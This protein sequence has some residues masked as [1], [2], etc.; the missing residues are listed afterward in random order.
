MK[1]N[2]YLNNDARPRLI[3]GIKKCAEAV[4]ATMGTSGSNAL[5]QAIEHPGH[6]ATNDGATILS[7]IKLADPI[8]DMGRL[9]LLEAVSRANKKSGDG[10]STAT[11]LTAAIIDAG[12]TVTDH[13]AMDIKRSLEACTELLEQ[14][15]QETAKAITVDDVAGVATISAE[16]ATIGQTIGDIYKQIGPDGIIHWDISKTNQDSYTIGN[17]ITIDGAGYVSPYM[18]DIDEKTGMFLNVARWK[19]PKVLITKQKI[20]TA[21]DFNSLFQNLYNNNIREVVIF[22]DEYEA[23]VIGDF[24][25]TRAVRGFKT[26]LVKMPVLWKDQWFIDLAK[27]SGATI[28]DPLAG[29][30]YKTMNESHLGTFEHIV[31]SKDSTFIDGIQNITEHI[32]ALEEE[33]TDDSK[34]RVARLNTKTARYYVGA[35]SES[36]LSYKRL[37]VEDAISAA[38]QALHG[39]VVAGGGVALKNASLTLPSTIGGEIL[40]KAL[41]RPMETITGNAGAYIDI[42]SLK[43]NEGIDTRT[44]EVVDMLDAGIID[45]ANV[46]INAVKNAISV[47]ATILTTTTVLTLPNLEKQIDTPPVVL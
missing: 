28:I 1:D 22:C 40:K 30:S 3:A 18:C 27:A 34:L 31:V 19:N 12:M 43:G 13:T 33:N 29:I 26:L 17:G 25:Q 45:P 44:K 20:T 38:W 23:N 8:E 32:A 41:I 39:G 5:I 35:D 42:A 14:S 9:I 11:V 2:L 21:S 24:V 47:A 36:A 37:K 7:S 16:D 10:S 46:A 4:G 6:L 15:I